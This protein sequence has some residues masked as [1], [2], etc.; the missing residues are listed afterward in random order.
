MSE[1][2]SGTNAN[3]PSCIP[4]GQRYTTQR[5]S[6]K[7]PSLFGLHTTRPHV[8][9]IDWY[10][11]STGFSILPCGLSPLTGERRWEARYGT[12]GA[13]DYQ[14]PARSSVSLPRSH[15]SPAQHNCREYQSQLLSHQQGSASS[16]NSADRIECVAR[17]EALPHCSALSLF[18]LSSLGVALAQTALLPAPSRASVSTSTPAPGLLSN[19]PV[20]AR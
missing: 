6:R 19:N 4:D 13:Q 3:H 7:Y 15:P 17:R 5:K 12:I 14:P 1:P 20:R 10:W 9:S 8:S 16:P 18:A 2:Q 11:Y